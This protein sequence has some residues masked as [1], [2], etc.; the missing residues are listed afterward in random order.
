MTSSSKQ[1]HNFSAGPS[2]LAASAFEKSIQDIQNF[3]GTGLSVLEVS[4]R[5][6]EFQAVMDQAHAL[7]K[8]LLG[9]NDDWDVLFLQGGASTQ[10]YQIPM[11]FLR[12]KAAYLNTGVW[13]KKSL[14]EAKAYGSVDVVASSADANFNHIPSVYSVPSDAD[15][16]HC[17]SNNTIYGTQMHSFIDSSV[18]MICDMSSD[19]FSRPVDISKFSMIYA[20]AQK[21]MGPAGVT[22]VAIRKSMYERVADRHIPTMLKYRV[23]AENGSMY[24]TPPVFPI[25]VSKY[26]LEW[27]KEM[28]GLE[29]MARRNQAKADLLYSAI[30]A[31]PVFKGTAEVE[32]R[33]QMNVCFVPQ[34]ENPELEAQFMAACKEAGISGVKGHRSVGG[35]R[36]SL[37]NALPIESVQALVQ[38]IQSFS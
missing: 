23:H 28:G 26:N 25:L 35:F 4:H 34:E 8:E 27:V 22:L 5:G 13:A 10:F 37:Y 29:A 31:S 38:V 12:S 9:L 36:A 7:V 19:I 1:V 14:A 6:K 18:P 15:Y 21:N 32:S 16:F 17:T 20:G 3:A 24:N 2:I 11:N 33:S 30:D